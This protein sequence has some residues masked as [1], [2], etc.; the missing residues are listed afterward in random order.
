MTR[1]RA[2]ASGERERGDGWMDVECE[3]RVVSVDGILCVFVGVEFDIVVV[4]DDG[5]GVCGMVCGGGERGGV[6]GV[7]GVDVVD[8]LFGVV[9]CVYYCWFDVYC[10]LRCGEW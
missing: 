8:G 1:A 5:Y 6:G 2:D 4:D 9:V 7:G 3:M 10:E